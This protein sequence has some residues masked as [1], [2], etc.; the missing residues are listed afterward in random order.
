MAGPTTTRR[1]ATLALLAAAALAA[2]ALA[3]PALAQDA[4]YERAPKR[5]GLDD[6]SADTND[7]RSYYN[8]GVKH[9]QKRPDRASAA[10]YWAS[11]LAPDRAE[12]IYARWVATWISRRTM[13][14]AYVNGSSADSPEARAVDSLQTA[15][16]VRDPFVHQG[17]RRSLEGAMNDRQFGEGKWVW[18]DTDESRAWLAYTEGKFDEAAKRFAQA[19][20][21]KRT[22][23][24]LHVARARAFYGAAK[25]DSAA[26]EM[27]IAIEQ[28]RL[29]DQKQLVYSYDSKAMFEY[30]LG[31]LHTMRKDYAAAKAAYGRALE[32]DLTFHIAYAALGGLALAQGDTAQAISALEDAIAANPNDPVIRHDLGVLLLVAGRPAEAVP[33]FHEAVRLAPEFAAAHYNYAAALEGVGRREDASVQYAEFVARAPRAFSAT[34][35]AA[36]ARIA[37]LGAH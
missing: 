12:P 32:E 16:L 6:A 3:T 28:M 29:H 25:I 9:I 31:V 19:I 14:S 7:W 20:G 37:A 10:F 13:L 27:A 24:D 26:A 22:R 15:A 30:S 5:P 35:G 18:E 11:R 33:H 21:A 36:R 8:Y 23:T 34:A 1:L 2:P 17:L 4:L